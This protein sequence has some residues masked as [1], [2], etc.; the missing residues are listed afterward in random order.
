[1]VKRK[2]WGVYDPE[3]GL[4]WYDSEEA[5]LRAACDIIEECRGDSVWQLDTLESLAV[6]RVTHVA[7]ERAI[8]LPPLSR[9]NGG[10]DMNE[11]WGICDY[12]MTPIDSTDGGDAQDEP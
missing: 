8:G 2:E 9:D 1:M 12:H 11:D 7:Q 3:Q 4:E 6:L 5:A 10:E